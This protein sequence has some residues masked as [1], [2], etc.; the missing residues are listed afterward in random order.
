[1]SV[2]E[3]GEQFRKLVRTSFADLFDQRHPFG[4]LALTQVLLTAGDTVF[5]VSLAG[6][7]FFSISPDAAKSKIVLYL[8]LT[9]APFAVVAPALGP[10]V[11]RS[12]GARRAMVVTSAL[13]RAILCVFLARDIHSLL[14]FPEAFAM[15]VLSKVFLITKGALVPEMAALGMLD[16]EPSTA[17]RAGGSEPSGDRPKVAPDHRGGPE[18]TP[19]Y[20]TP[21]AGAP[22]AG[23]EAAS[24]VRAS[25]APGLAALNAR[26]GLLASLSAFV[27]AGPAIVVLK[28]GSASGVLWLGV[29]VFLG[30]VVAAARL[31]VTRSNRRTG[32]RGRSD[33]APRSSVPVAPDGSGDGWTQDSLDV[34]A[35]SPIAPSEVLL[36][37]L[38]MSVLKA[39]VGFLTFLFAFGLRREGAATWWFGLLLGSITA[40]ALVGVLLVARIRRVFSE[41]Q[42]LVGSLWLVAAVS[43]TA[44]VVSG[45]LVQV[46]VAFGV[47]VAGSLSKPSFDAL[48]QQH[49]AESNQGRAFSRSE[50]RFQ[51]AWVLG[52]F[53]P[54]VLTLSIATGD[55]VILALAVVGAL[56]TMS[57]L[58]AEERSR[59]ARTRQAVAGHG[60]S[61]P[62]RR[63]R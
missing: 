29:A 30:G 21:P 40:G 7:L 41:H 31:P 19:P 42:I 5:A 58:A 32:R 38:P 47:G 22:V 24:T 2:R 6:S 43:A 9:I 52:S 3:R 46:V 12:R 61:A 8:L 34:A 35:L 62:A 55:V 18:P 25:V 15:L 59:Q 53:F 20:G 49:V 57:S 56:V 11:D 4:R 33:D 13:G 60:P 17:T 37:M 45:R 10:L 39:L 14:L 63:S 23:A 54:V 16:V 44:I 1:M 27:A 36:A 48:M 50:T 51:L 28:L 26:L